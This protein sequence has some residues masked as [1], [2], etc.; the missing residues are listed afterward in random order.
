MEATSYRAQEGLVLIVTSQD[1]LVHWPSTFPQNSNTR[2]VEEGITVPYQEGGASR[3]ANALIEVVSNSSRAGLVPAWEVFM[4][5]R[6]PPTP[7]TA[8]NVRSSDKSKSNISSNAPEYDG[9][10]KG[11]KQARKRRNKLKEGHRHC[12]RQRK[13]AWDTYEAE[14]TEYNKKKSERKAKE[15]HNQST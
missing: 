1:C 5:R 8:L 4:I 13:E 12:A 7:P 15:R 6:P 2:L 9:E 14:L 3:D 10:S 11:H